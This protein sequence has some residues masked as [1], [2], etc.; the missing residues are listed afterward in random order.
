MINNLFEFAVKCLYHS[1][2]DEK[3]MLTKQAKQLADN[4]QLIILCKSEIIPID[5]VVFPE[6]PMLVAPRDLPRRR[7]G[8]LNG[9]IALLHAVAH[10]EF[11]AIYLAWDIIYRFRGLSD[12]FYLDWLHVASDEAIHFAL[13]CDRL[14]ELGS[15]YGQLPAHKGLWNVAVNTADDLLARLA[16]VPRYMEARGLDATPGMV[17]RLIKHGDQVSADLLQRIVDDEVTHVRYGS[18]WFAHVCAQRCLNPEQAYFECLEQYLQGTLR[19]PF[20]H[21]LRKQA[22]FSQAEI[23]Q[24]E[25]LSGRMFGCADQ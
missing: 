10:I 8:T 23:N 22:G 18:E 12:Q 16:L 14:R 13:I 9:R 4:H 25:A 24:L 2:I 7:L 17:E 3:L 21:E 20:N 5:Q 6:S 15:D 11:Y 19:G 1:S